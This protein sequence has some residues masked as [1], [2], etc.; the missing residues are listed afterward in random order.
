MPLKSPIMVAPAL[1]DHYADTFDQRPF[2]IYFNDHF[3]FSLPFD[4]TTLCCFFFL[5]QRIKHTCMRYMYIKTV[6]TNMHSIVGTYIYKCIKFILLPFTVSLVCTC[7]N[8]NNYLLSSPWCTTNKCIL[9][10]MLFLL[11]L[12]INKILL[13][14]R[15]IM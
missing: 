4:N 12:I 15:F 6:N 5:F 2:L 3:Y 14:V 9:F 7:K 11:L 10:C 8:V 1:S 13:L